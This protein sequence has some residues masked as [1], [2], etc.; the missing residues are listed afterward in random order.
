MS[1]P[2][3]YLVSSRLRPEQY[4]RVRQIVSFTPLKGVIALN[5]EDAE[6]AALLSAEN[7]IGFVEAMAIVADFPGELAC[8][9]EDGTVEVIECQSD[10]TVVLT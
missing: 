7:I 4:E 1:T 9:N 2:K 10:P 5:K 6:K 8:I 3:L